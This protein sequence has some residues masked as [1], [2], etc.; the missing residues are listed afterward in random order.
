MFTKTEVKARWLSKMEKH[1]IKRGSIKKY[2][3]SGRPEET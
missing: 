3:G 2:Q 1:A